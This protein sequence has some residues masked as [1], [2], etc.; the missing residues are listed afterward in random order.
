MATQAN[1]LPT[2]IPS[3]NSTGIH[4]V[5][6]SAGP[7]LSLYIHQ[8]DLHETTR[9]GVVALLLSGQIDEPRRV[10]AFDAHE[11]WAKDASQEIAEE[12]VRRAHTAGVD[13]PY[14]TA[15][16]VGRYVLSRYAA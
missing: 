12:L 15:R 4:V 1:S 11:G 6:A 7:R 3:G 14:G 16:F 10:L 2:R 13:L 8:S 9:D 5:E